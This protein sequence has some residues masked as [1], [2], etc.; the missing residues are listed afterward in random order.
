MSP[1]ATMGD[2]TRANAGKRDYG[3]SNARIRGMRSRLLKRDVLE[4]LAESADLHELVQELM[5]TDYAVDLEDALIHGRGPNEVGEGL[6]N[7]LVRTYRKVFGF[8]N[9]EAADI[10]SAVLGR[11]DVFN[12][13]TILRGKHVHL[14]NTEIADGL[15]PVGALSQSDLEGLV[16]Q[17]DIRSV[18]DTAMTWGLPQSGALREGFVEYARTGDLAGFELALDRRYSEWAAQLLAR[19]GAN[20][21]LARRILTTQVD[22]ENLLMVLRVARADLDPEEAE[23]YFLAGGKDVTLDLYSKLAAMSEVDEI[24]DGLKGSRFGMVLEEAAE[25]YLESQSISVFERALEDFLTRKAIALGGGDPLGVGIPIAYLWSKNN[26][27]TNV[28]IVARGI[29]VGMPVERMRREL[30][31]V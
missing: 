31:L 11:W 7:N 9:Q 15:L 24:L 21:A 13:K 14:S 22:I 28:R 16:R 17:P 20:A 5:Q 1:T 18:V 12:L 26:E 8:L 3:Y 30:I 6:R 2:S 10:C 4:R 19:R 27:V 25:R 23:R 29:A